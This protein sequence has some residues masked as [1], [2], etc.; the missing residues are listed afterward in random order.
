[1][2]GFEVVGKKG[3]SEGLKGIENLRME[4]L[5]WVWVKR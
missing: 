5:F 3:L 4:V 1:M 2:A